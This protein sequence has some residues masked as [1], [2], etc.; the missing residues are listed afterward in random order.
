MRRHGT[1][2]VNAGSM[3]DIAFLLLIF[4]LI[5]TTLEADSGINRKLPPI[6][7]TPSNITFKE[8][9]V[10]KV[11]INKDK[12]ILMN[13]ELIDVKSVKKRIIT[14]LDNGGGVGDL[15]CEYCKG[16]R[17]KTSSEHPIKAI[18]AV[19][20]SNEI[21]YENYIH[22][23]NELIA[24]YSFLRNREALRLYSVTYD[25]L[26]KEYKQESDATRKKQLR[27]IKKLYPEH[28]VEI[29]SNLLNL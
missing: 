2:E 25:Q 13:E 28:I 23:L 15:L 4:F 7:D 5:T 29:V 1:Q 3:A 9:N 17:S 22:V 12:Q 16:S 10:L 8:R 20:Y 21:S 14:F 18:I 6:V 27:E 26:L 19:Q 24:G 11:Q